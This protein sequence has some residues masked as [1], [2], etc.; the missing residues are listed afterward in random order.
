MV[1]GNRDDI[2][3]VVLLAGT[4]VSGKENC[5]QLSLVSEFRQEHCPKNNEIGLHLFPLESPIRPSPKD[6]TFS[7]SSS[8]GIVT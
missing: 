2:A 4:G 1:A 6:L 5:S 8:K 7:V 3:A